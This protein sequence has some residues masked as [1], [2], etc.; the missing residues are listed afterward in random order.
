[1]QESQEK[2]P[3]GVTPPTLFL[4]LPA[5]LSGSTAFQHK[6]NI[7]PDREQ[8]RSRALDR[9]IRKKLFEAKNVNAEG[10]LRKEPS[11]VYQ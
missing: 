9:L 1:M 10:I 4:R 6:V 11:D 8:N 5:R 3:A 2:R 7:V